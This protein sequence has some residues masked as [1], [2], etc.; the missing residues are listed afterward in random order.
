ML[1]CLQE[2]EGGRAR[3]REGDRVRERESERGGSCLA[4]I[5]ADV[6]ATSAVMAPWR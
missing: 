2:R 4:S 3:E 6:L 1:A 5:Y